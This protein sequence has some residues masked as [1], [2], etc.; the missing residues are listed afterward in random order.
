MRELKGKRETIDEFL[1]RMFNVVLGKNTDMADPENMENMFKAAKAA[2]EIYQEEIT[3]LI[4]TVE[5]DPILK[6]KYVHTYTRFKILQT[7]GPQALQK[8]DYEIANTGKSQKELAG[9]YLSLAQ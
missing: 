7:N 3:N 6:E 1:Y 9:K 8:M 5:H 2:I 4:E